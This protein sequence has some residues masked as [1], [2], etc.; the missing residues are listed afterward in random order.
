MTR[1][2]RSRR[3]ASPSLSTG[4]LAAS[5]TMRAWMRGAFRRRDLVLEGGGHEDV[6]VEFEDFAGGLDGAR[7]RGAA[8]GAGLG[9]VALDGLDV[10]ARVGGD[11]A[12]DLGDGDDARAL[13]AQEAGSVIAHLPQALNDDALALD[14]GREA[15]GGHVGGGGGRL[16]DADGDAAAR[17]LGA[18]GDAV[19]GDG[20][21]RDAG[22]GVEL[23]GVEDGVG[24]DDPG[25]LALARAVVR[26]GHVDGGA[27]H[28]LAVEFGD[29]AAG[30]AFEEALA[31]GAG[32]DGR[33]RPWPRRRGSR[34]WRT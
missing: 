10:E 19:E 28:V 32:V 2:P 33:R 29:V 27:D 34:R 23:V 8:D 11:A 21:A 20:L 7:S 4:P 5:A 30:G 31:L 6:A 17:G 9:A 14:A 13:L 1:T 12:V 24:V 16:G 3:M 26:G 18:T 22:E 15:D 25:H